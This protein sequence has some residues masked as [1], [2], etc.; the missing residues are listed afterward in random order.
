[1]D[2]TDFAVYRYLSKDGEARFW[3]GRRVIDPRITPR[4]IAEI[5][6]ISESGARTRLHHLAERGF[7]R[8]QAVTPNPSLFGLQVFVTDLLVRQ[9]GQVDHILRDLMLVDEV[10]FTRDVIDED[11]RTIQVHFACDGLS[12]ASRLAGLLGRFS[13]DG[14]KVAARP[15]YIP[16]CDRE[17]SPLDWRVLHAAWRHPEATFAEIAENVGI[18]LKS[19]A[20]SYHQ[21]LD[22]KA[23]WWS[24]GPESE[25]FPLALVCVNLR[26]PSF[27]ESM[28]EWFDQ[29][30]S[31]WMPV[32][33]DGF[34]LEAQSATTVL[35]ALL[36]ADLP[37]S[38]ERL[39]RKL[40]GV[41]GVD[42]IRRTFPLGSAIYTTWFTDRI[43]GSA[44]A[45]A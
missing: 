24:H 16:T 1:M 15:Y 10:V 26:D 43:P 34:G 41:D 38:L 20:R 17:L 23:C 28:T 11:Q 25:E 6:G 39:L 42:R 9:S 35:A 32:A 14:G 37:T 21:L 44:R 33:G 18:S 8:D 3:A 4:E 5:V 29:E 31:P 2:P 22:A 45:Q 27:R 12:A 30:A 36:P 13:T 19:A 7:L 40:A